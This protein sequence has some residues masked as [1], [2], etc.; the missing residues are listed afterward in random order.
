[1]IFKLIDECLG[2]ILL[3]PIVKFILYI[4][5]LDRNLLVLISEGL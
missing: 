5:W 3:L 2:S 4:I 1:M